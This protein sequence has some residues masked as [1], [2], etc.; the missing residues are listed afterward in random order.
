MGMFSLQ[1]NGTTST[2]LTTLSLNCW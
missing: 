1:E 2:F